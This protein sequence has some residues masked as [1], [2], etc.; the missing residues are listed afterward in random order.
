MSV[1]DDIEAAPEWDGVAEWIATDYEKLGENAQAGFWF[2]TASQLT[3]AG[4][5]SP[6]Q[7]KISQALFFVQRAS[8]CYSRCG[9]EGEMA[10]ARTRAISVVL[11][12][13]C[14]PA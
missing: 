3:L 1:L 12:R 8:N 5:A 10:S 11:E 7:R 9:E 2:E 6:V 13:A 14:P 4:D